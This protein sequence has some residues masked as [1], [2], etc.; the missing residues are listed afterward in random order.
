VTVTATATCA[1]IE[2]SF[3]MDLEPAFKAD[4]DGEKSFGQI[5]N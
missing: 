5:V 4:G 1:A 2:S 3:A